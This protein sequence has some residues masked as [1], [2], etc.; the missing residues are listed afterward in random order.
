M[1][2]FASAPK[3]QNNSTTLASSKVAG[4]IATSSLGGWYEDRFRSIDVVAVVQ[5]IFLPTTCQPFLIDD[6]PVDDL[7]ETWIGENDD[8]QT[9]KRRTCLRC[10]GKVLSTSAPSTSIL[11]LRSPIEMVG[12]SSAPMERP[13]QPAASLV[14]SGATMHEHLKGVLPRECVSRSDGKK[15]WWPG[16]LCRDP[17]ALAFPLGM[18]GQASQRLS[19]TNLESR[20]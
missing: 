17:S 1:V 5:T 16:W 3:V 12:F 18:P 9:Y 4:I 7:H 19:G 14:W 15:C 11:M 6:I 13:C 8:I 2:I 20:V 10:H